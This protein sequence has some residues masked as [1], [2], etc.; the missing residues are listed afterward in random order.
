MDKD[1]EIEQN[2]LEALRKMLIE[3]EESTVCDYSLEKL[4]S[5]LDRENAIEKNH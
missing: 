3:G 1:M 2:K 5:E 4:L